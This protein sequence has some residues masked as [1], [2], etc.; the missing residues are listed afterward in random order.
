MVADYTTFSRHENDGAM[1]SS[2]ISCF[3][4]ILKKTRKTTF[5]VFPLEAAQKPFLHPTTT[6]FIQPKITNFIQRTTRYQGFFLVFPFVSYKSRRLMKRVRLALT[7]RPTG[8]LVNTSLTL[9]IK[10]SKRA[11]RHKGV[12]LCFLL[13][14]S[15]NN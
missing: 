13:H 4:I 9:Y 8:R 12:F 14:N 7:N 3:D 1:M 11:V 5:D 10:G 15:A 2:V 6:N